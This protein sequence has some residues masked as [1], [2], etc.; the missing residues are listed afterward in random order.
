MSFP[1]WMNQLVM[2]WSWT[3]EDAQKTSR[4]DEKDFD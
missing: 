4:P 2:R 3:L 1:E